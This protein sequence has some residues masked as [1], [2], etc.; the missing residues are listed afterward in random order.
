MT[1]DRGD[2]ARR[3]AGRPPVPASVLADRMAAT[4]VHHEP[5]WRLPR[6]TALARRYNVS[7]AEVDAAIEELAA[8][9]LLR[10]LP[11]GQVYR[12]SPAEYRIPLEGLSGL[13][14]QVDPMGGQLACKSRHV[15]RRRPPE[16]IGRSLGLEA[17]EPV[18]AVRCV[19]TV[20]GEPAALSASYLPEHLAHLLPD[21]GAPPFGPL[22]DRLP[23]EGLPP[24]GTAAG[25]T[26][27]AGRAA[28]G[29]G[30]DGPAAGPDA[31]PGGGSSP[32]PGTG[33]GGDRPGPVLTARVRALQVE[34]APP[35]SSV[36]RSL[37]L[38]AGEPVAMVTAGFE[39]QATGRP[40]AITTAMLRPDLFRIVIQA[41]AQ[42]T[43]AGLTDGMAAVWT[44]DM[45]G[46][47]P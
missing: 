11:D 22:G 28:G 7:V 2:D 46:W 38:G 47:E 32:A 21:M 35:P 42:P 15:S 6:L 45:Q 8:R 26:E 16:D 44:H 20:G 37:R 34:L 19:W 10:R 41:T 23:V 5:G 3:A 43:P 27:V 13:A 9:H 12:A 33:A 14:S 39:D 29:P 4:L 18:L 30:A 17:G 36:A 24:A 40:V 1:A 31:A 25:D